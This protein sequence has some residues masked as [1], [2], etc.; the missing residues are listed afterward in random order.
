[1]QEFE[2]HPIREYRRLRF[3]SG[4]FLP[5]IIIIR[6]LR[7]FSSNHHHQQERRFTNT[8]DSAFLVRIFS[9]LNY[10]LLGYLI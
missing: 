8:C 9:L 6:Y 5:W 4:T 3:C 1:M 2:D 7:N 10:S